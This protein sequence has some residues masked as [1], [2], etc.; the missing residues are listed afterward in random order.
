M[1]HLELVIM[2]MIGQQ[3]TDLEHNKE[4]KFQKLQ[5]LHHGQVQ[6]LNNQINQDQ[7]HQD[8]VK[9]LQMH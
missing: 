4:N 7:H 5:V 6:R 9:E 8:L 1:L 2:L 3:A